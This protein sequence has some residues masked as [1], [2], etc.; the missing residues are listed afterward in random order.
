MDLSDKA[1]ATVY[2]ATELLNGLR[3]EL[4]VLPKQRDPS[5]KADLTTADIIETGVTTKGMEA[6][7]RAILEKHHDNFL[8]D[9]NAVPAPARRV[10]GD[11]NVDDAKPVAR[12][13]RSIRPERLRKA[14]DQLENLL[15]TELIEYS[16]SE[17]ASPIV[18]VMK[19][20]G[21]DIG[22]C[23]DYRIA[24]Q[25]IRRTHYPL[26]LI[27]DL[28]IGFESV[29]WVLSLAVAKRLWA[30]PMTLWAKHISVLICLLRR[31]QWTKMLLGLKNAPPICQQMLVNCLWSF[32]RLPASEAAQMDVDGLAFLGVDVGDSAQA[33]TLIECMTGF[34]RN[35]P[36]SSQLKPGWEE[37]SYVDD[38]GYGAETWE[39]L[40]V[41]LD[42]LLYWLRCWGTSMSLLKSKLGKKMISCLS[43]EIEADR[44]QAQPKIT[45]GVKG[46]P[47][48]STLKDVQSFLTSL[49]YYNEFNEGLPV[50]AAVLNKLTDEQIQ[51]G[52]DLGRA[53]EAFGI[54]KRKIMSTTLLRGPDSQKSFVII[55]H[56]NPWAGCAVLG[57]ESDGV[58]FPGFPYDVGWDDADQDLYPILCAQVDIHIA[59]ARGTL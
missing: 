34:P 17:W 3:N 46:L 59:V 58:I 21:G 35:V 36:A 44:I 11:F 43:H 24:L 28:L 13:F 45:E 40:C 22:T 29:L 1:E 33:D 23:I 31:F 26:P 37:S 52:R 32:V 38:I 20:N 55:I 57:Q 19:K 18:I 7:A 30:V 12:R 16:H 50:I 53:M 25:L 6:Q 48:S 8:E 10:I 4:A 5:P 15:Q 42:R 47:S 54:L 27:D 39:Q 9:G 14:Y 2:E 41:D 51:S 56:A 49:N